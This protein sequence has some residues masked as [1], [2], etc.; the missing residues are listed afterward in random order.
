MTNTTLNPADRE[1]T[2][3]LPRFGT[4]TYRESEVL[5]FPSGLPGFASH[6]RFVAIQFTS[7]EH[8]IWLQSLDDVSVA[9]PTADP[10]AIFEEYSPQLPPYASALLEIQSPEEFAALCVVVA[11][12][13]ADMTI[14]LLAPIVI[15]LRTRRA[16]QV[17]LETGGY[18]VR[19]TIPPKRAWTQA[20]A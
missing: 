19:T 12:N 20:G 4:L 10:W 2:I 13:V 18:S 5:T 14:N 3:K 7:Q 15:N 16:H 1:T 8:L 9:L 6:R 17:A 11:G